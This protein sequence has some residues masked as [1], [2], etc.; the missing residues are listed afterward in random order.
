[1][2]PSFTALAGWHDAF[3]EIL[4]H[5]EPP[6]QD[7]DEGYEREAY[8]AAISSCRRTWLS[9]AL[10]SHALSNPSLNKLWSSLTCVTPLLRLLPNFQHH[11]GTYVS[12]VSS[13]TYSSA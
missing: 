8:P 3:H 9:L 11:D 6:T 5:L 2:P 10:S 1:M 4:S 12:R 7:Y 13:N